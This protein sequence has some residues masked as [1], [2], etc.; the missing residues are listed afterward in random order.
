MMNRMDGIKTSMVMRVKFSRL[1]GQFRSTFRNSQI[2]CSTRD[3][4]QL[5][6]QSSCADEMRDG[7]GSLQGCLIRFRTRQCPNPVPV[8]ER[9]NDP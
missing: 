1:S 8:R 9:G 6:S 7:L 2:L 5:I 4:A 3:E